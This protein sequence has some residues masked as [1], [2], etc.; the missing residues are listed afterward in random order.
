MVSIKTH[1]LKQQI[2]KVIEVT[3]HDDRPGKLF[4]TFM[5]VLI[6]LNVLAFTFETVDSVSIPYKSYF[7]DFETISVMIFTL[8]YGFRVWTCTL[9]PRYR[10]P[11]L[12]RCKFILSPLAIVDFISVLPYY[13][14][15]VF[16]N[17]VFVRELHLLRL[18]RL[19]K[20]GRY[21][22]S[23][24]TLGTVISSK[25]EDLFS[26]LFTVFTLLMISSSLMY[27]AEHAAQP[28]RYPNIPASMWWGIITL[29]SVGYGDV[30]PITAIGR[31][32]GGIIAVLGLGL[33]A[34][35]TG[36]IASGF[37][38]EVEKKRAHLRRFCPHC[39]E[40]LDQ[41]HQKIGMNEQ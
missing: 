33:V 20:I 2:Y 3:H 31:L 6:S 17:L 22:E 19:F 28:D 41:P 35:P 5:I 21:S 18:A 1:K 34:L 4:D 38:E 16:P 36:I 40:D 37:A 7:N 23:M 11:V 14:F 24:R 26:A 25:R 27:Y 10:H 8:E 30:A 12:G 32:L 29:T 15:L 9:S 13:L 39:G